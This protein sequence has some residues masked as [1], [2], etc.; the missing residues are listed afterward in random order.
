MISGISGM[1][2]WS[3][4]GVYGASYAA[5]AQGADTLTASAAGGPGEAYLRSCGFAP[6][7][8]AEGPA[9]WRKFIGFDPSI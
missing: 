7:E 9:L 8:Q 3:A 1:S 5:R 2:P 6:Q 4:Y